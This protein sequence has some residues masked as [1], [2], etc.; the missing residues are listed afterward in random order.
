MTPEIKN[1]LI[2]LLCLLI[3]APIG[4]SALLGINELMEQARKENNRKKKFWALTS[5]M[6]FIGVV[7]G[8]LR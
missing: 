6:F 7:L 5:L 2:R 8:W 4:G 3:V 1:F